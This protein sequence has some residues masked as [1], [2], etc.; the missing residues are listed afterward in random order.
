MDRRGFL[1]AAGTRPSS[2]GESH[3]LTAIPGGSYGLSPAEA[4][5]EALGSLYEDGR[6]GEELDTTKT[7]GT[8]DNACEPEWPD[9]SAESAC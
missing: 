9:G 7:Q 5:A 8:D 6:K 1:Q 2:T 3:P 4:G